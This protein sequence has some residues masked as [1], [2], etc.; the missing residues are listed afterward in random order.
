MREAPSIA[1]FNYDVIH[2]IFGYVNIGT[3][4]CLG[5]TCR[6]LYRCLKMKYPLDIRLST[7]ICDHETNEE[8]QT[9]QPHIHLSHILKSWMGD[10]YRLGVMRQ[11]LYLKK[12]VYG[13]ESNS[14]EEE[15]LYDRYKDYLDIRYFRVMVDDWEP[16]WIFGLGSK[17]ND[18]V[19]E[20]MIVDFK[21]WD[22]FGVWHFFWKKTNVY[23]KHQ[24]L[25]DGMIEEYMWE[26]W[27]EGIALMGF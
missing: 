26:K 19:I 25:I 13:G 12:E 14:P 7:M 18:E 11:H 24:E 22:D 2:L 16:S 10:G 3:A 21:C 20:Q 8:W 15:A 5:L 9:H 4:V 1:N 17:W 6:H 23:K 27:S